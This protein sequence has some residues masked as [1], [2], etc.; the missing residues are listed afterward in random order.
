ML[1]SRPPTHSFWTL[2]SASGS[3]ALDYEKKILFLFQFLYF[4]VFLFYYFS[5][6]LFFHFSIFPFL[7]QRR[8]RLKIWIFVGL[9]P[10][11][12]LASPPAFFHGSR[13]AW[14]FDSH[15][16]WKPA[17]VSFKLMQDRNHEN[18][19][20]TSVKHHFMAMVV[21]QVGQENWLDFSKNAE[22]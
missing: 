9:L 5:I 17:N 16:P 1:S 7:L 3:C 4:C 18:F 22:R 21:N 13:G 12:Q 6:F 2:A 20:F 15:Q 14:P 19:S 11:V 8:F 10:W